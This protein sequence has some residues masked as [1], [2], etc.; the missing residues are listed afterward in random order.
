[1]LGF[2]QEMQ[3]FHRYTVHGFDAD[4]EILFGLRNVVRVGWLFEELHFVL[5]QEAANVI[6][7]VCLGK[8]LVD[9]LETG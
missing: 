7:V 1:M 8:S 5:A 9:N 6:D 2:P 3:T 4:L